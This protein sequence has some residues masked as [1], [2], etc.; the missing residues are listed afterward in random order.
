MSQW[1]VLNQGDVGSQMHAQG[2][3]KPPDFQ[4]SIVCNVKTRDTEKARTNKSPFVQHRLSYTINEPG[5]FTIGR[6]ELGFRD[7]HSVNVGTLRQTILQASDAFVYTAFNYID[8]SVEPVFLGIIDLPRDTT[9]RDSV[10]RMDT[11]VVAMSGMRATVNT[12]DD[13]I[14]P[15]DRVIWCY[16]EMIRSATTGEE[17]PKH[18]LTGVPR[19]KV[20]PATRPLN[21]LSDGSVSPYRNLVSKYNGT[22]RQSHDVNVTNLDADL[23]QLLG[24][25]SWHDEGYIN[26]TDLMHAI[27]EDDGTLYA[28]FQGTAILSDIA[29]LNLGDDK[30][31]MLLLLKIAAMHYNRMLSRQIGIATNTSRT[32]QQLD[33]M[34][35]GGRS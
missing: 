7:G 8:K 5:V 15:G 31:K 18:R 21:F 20:L 1:V 10:R 4:S 27:I 16:P 12:G 25:D 30:S 35:R 9:K 22:F 34:V 28:K 13:P 19:R 29:A 2:V 32:G 14:F 3:R 24:R 6:Y 33:I 23:P 17:L 11:S 26:F